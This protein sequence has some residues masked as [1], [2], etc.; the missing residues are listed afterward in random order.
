VLRSA[1]EREGVAGRIDQGLPV[2]A[3]LLGHVPAE[4]AVALPF[5]R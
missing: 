3:G 1:L 4:N 2:Q 5:L